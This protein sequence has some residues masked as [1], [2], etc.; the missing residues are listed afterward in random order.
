MRKMITAIAASVAL[1][2]AGQRAQACTGQHFSVTNTVASDVGC[3]FNVT[4]SM[5]ATYS[6]LI[7][8]AAD[9]VSASYIASQL[10]GQGDGGSVNVTNAEAGYATGEGNIQFTVPAGVGEVI[11][12][13]DAT[14]G[15]Q[16]SATEVL[17]NGQFQA[18]PGG[19]G[20][21]CAAP[22]PP[23]PVTPP[24]NTA[25]PGPGI[26]P[27]DNKAAMNDLQKG[28][29]PLNDHDGDDMGH[30]TGKVE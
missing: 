25:V 4:V 5:D 9:A 20:G 27:D 18:A 10:N 21:G 24:V 30:R 3:I 19:A 28:N 12:T 2:F 16:G 29:V 1:A 7:N 14:D 17:V 11:V 22:P 15:S 13:V 6:T 26:D 8:G 23:A